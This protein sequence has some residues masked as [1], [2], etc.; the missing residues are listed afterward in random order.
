[1]PHSDGK[2]A[3]KAFETAMKISI[4]Q[5]LAGATPFPGKVPL[6]RSKTSLGF[7]SLPE[8]GGGAHSPGMDRGGSQSPA[9]RS[10]AFERGGAH[11]PS[12]PSLTPSRLT[13]DHQA[14]LSSGRMSVLGGKGH[15]EDSGGYSVPDNV[16]VSTRFVRSMPVGHVTA[17][18]Q[19][20]SLDKREREIVRKA[21]GVQWR[22]LYDEKREGNRGPASPPENKD[23]PVFDPSKETREEREKRR[24]VRRFT[25]LL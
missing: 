7:T 11:S 3:V 6:G 1:M 9:F 12:L 13:H 4:R 14:T 19:R 23:Q 2:A 22:R 17:L 5:G 24:K 15:E 16:S 10:P 20:G 25:A 18:L 8:R 21:Q